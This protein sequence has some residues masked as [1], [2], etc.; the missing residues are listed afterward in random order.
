MKYLTLLSLIV[1]A[2]WL[3]GCQE[4]RRGLDL[5][6]QDCFGPY[7]TSN[8]SIILDGH[9]NWT[10]ADGDHYILSFGENEGAA[11][12]AL[13]I[14]RHY[15]MNYQCFVGNPNGGYSY[16]LVDGELPQGHFEGEDCTRINPDDLEVNEREGGWRVV[17]KAV[18]SGDRW[19]ASFEN[20]ADARRWREIVQR[21]D[22]RYVCVVNR[23]E[24]Q[25]MTY[26][27]R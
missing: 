27:R 25:C 17:D 21:F 18:G 9:G 15:G 10:I 3:T 13:E 11:E 2:S 12:K 14:I 4:T 8:L 23:G 1:V 19:L 26:F 24:P 20:E 16:W 6:E 7:D 22:V 5:T